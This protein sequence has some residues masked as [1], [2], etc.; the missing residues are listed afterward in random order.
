MKT[1]VSLPDDLFRRA[2]TAARRLRLS[3]S[4]LYAKA[5]AEFLKQQN[6]SAVTERL[7]DVYSQHPAKVDAGLYRA[8]LRSLA[9]D[10]W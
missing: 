8:Q 9:K 2:E 10:N 6:R 4:K 5:L 1:A 7:N 3:R